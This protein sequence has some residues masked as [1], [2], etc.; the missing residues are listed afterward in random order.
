MGFGGG[1][2]QGSSTTETDFSVDLGGVP[3]NITP[4]SS[5]G[6]FIANPDVTGVDGWGLGVGV[7][8]G[9]GWDSTLVGR[10]GFPTKAAT[11]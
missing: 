9:G 8:T 6:T 11:A 1:G 4:L 2:A 5:N 7:N 10:T 3:S